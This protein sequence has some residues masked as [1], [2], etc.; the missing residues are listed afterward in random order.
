MHQIFKLIKEN[1]YENALYEIEKYRP[2]FDELGTFNFAKGLVY[3]NL[4]KQ[5]KSIKFFR[6]LINDKK[7]QED[8]LNNILV[9]L[10]QRNKKKSVRKLID[11]LINLNS[12]KTYIKFNIAKF[13]DH[14]GDY[15]KSL[16]HL[17]NIHEKFPEK[18]AYQASIY[19][20]KNM[21]DIALDVLN[22]HPSFKDDYFIQKEKSSCLA[23]KENYSGALKTLDNLV[24]KFPEDHTLLY[25]KS[26]YLLHTRNTKKALKLFHTRFEKNKAKEKFPINVKLWDGSSAEKIL[27]W[28]E[29][30]LGDHIL[31]LKLVS[32]IQKVKKIYI[33]LDKRLHKLYQNYLTKNNITNIFILNSKANL[34]DFDYH[35]PAGDLMKYVDINKLKKIKFLEEDSP[36]K[37]NKKNNLNI[38]LSWKTLNK[39]QF[40]RSL[41][42]ENL[43]KTIKTIPNIQIYNLQFGDI[44]HEVK[45]CLKNKIDFNIIDQLDYTNHIDK[46]ASLISG[47]DLIVT[48]QNTIAHL[49]SAIN[50]NTIL[51]LPVG[52]RWY[53]NFSA[54]D[55]IDLWYKSTL[56]IKQNKINCW[57]NVLEKLTTELQNNAKTKNIHR[58]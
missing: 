51:L 38:G 16:E 2:A 50:A 31:Y 43:I 22:K 32:S 56:T 29:D 41:P 39:D 20:K 46:L 25:S 9:I 15:D 8:A 47:L 33:I 18:I 11:T 7:Y 21:L 10:K 27:V 54:D 36:F 17:E 42:F 44:R 30:G 55:N 12:N 1:N 19:R 6:K 5:S 45:Y 40:F 24:N 13:Y 34:D 53:W 48:C 3:L 37:I 23:Y 49:S 26:V 35:V 4:K 28:S 52:H 57:K 58:I 14:L